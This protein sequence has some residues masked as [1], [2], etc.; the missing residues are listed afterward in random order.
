M[1]NACLS[2]PPRSERTLAW[3]EGPLG[4]LCDGCPED[5][6]LQPLFWPTGER[7]KDAHAPGCSVEPSSA[8]RRVPYVCRRSAL[9][10]GRQ[11]AAAEHICDILS[12]IC[13]AKLPR[14]KSLPWCSRQGPKGPL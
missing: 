5:A 12:P 14:K 4:S 11:D 10:V 6:E 9:R 7:T 1:L 8:Q 3:R 2:G 13:L